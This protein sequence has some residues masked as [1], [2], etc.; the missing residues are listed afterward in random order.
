MEQI[1]FKLEFSVDIKVI[2]KV[3][4][5]R[6]IEPSLANMKKLTSIYKTRLYN[7]D[8]KFFDDIP[9]DKEILVMYGLKLMKNK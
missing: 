8:E 9:K 5:S 3:L 1:K 7:A 2:K 6:G 4:E